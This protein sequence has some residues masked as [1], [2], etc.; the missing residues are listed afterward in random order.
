MKRGSLSTW[1]MLAAFAFPLLATAPIQVNSN[2]ATEPETATPP[3]LAPANS[4]TPL[5]PTNLFAGDNLAPPEI[6]DAAF[7]PI[8]PVKPL[9]PTIRPTSPVAEVIKLANS[10]LDQSVLL[11][12]VTNS[13]STFNLDADKIIYLNDIG[14]PGDV[15]SAMIQRDQQ[16]RAQSDAAAAALVSTPLPAPGPPPADSTPAPYAVEAPPTAPEDNMDPA[17]Y[18]TLAPYG[19]WVDVNGYGPCWQPSVVVINSGWQPYFDCGHWAYS[20]CGWYWCSDYSWGWAPFHYGRWFRHHNLGWC[21]RP[22]RVWGPSWVCWSYSGDYCGWAPLPPAAGFSTGVG[23]T[24]AGH[25]APSGCHFGLGANH[26][27]YVAWNHFSDRHLRPYSLGPNQTEHIF[28]QSAVT[29]GIAVQNNRIVNIGISPERVAAATHMPVNQIALHNVGGR[30]NTIP[31][32]TLSGVSS[33]GAS[34]FNNG[35]FVGSAPQSANA[36]AGGVFATRTPSSSAWTTPSPNGLA[37]NNGAELPNH[38]DANSSLVVHGSQQ[39][40]PPEAN[41]RAPAN[42]LVVIGRNNQ[43]SYPGQ[44]NPW[45]TGMP[46]PQTPRQGPIQSSE[47]PIERT[48]NEVPRYNYTPVGSPFSYRAAQAPAMPSAPRAAVSDTTRY[49]QPAATLAPARPADTRSAPAAQ[50]APTAGAG[51]GH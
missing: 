44:Q 24:Y 14:V 37:R 18:D 25:P 33:T 26:F 16:I 40:W 8:S 20:N 12:F 7:T 3:D 9:P 27:H 49:S 42:S 21:W 10:G 28:G 1:R 15:V 36:T 23:L 6:S 29:T 43:G 45:A 13:T 35:R 5:A 38:P 17:F 41:N 39:I 48:V 22:E 46:M 31:Q 34:S 2:A 51:R 32:R 19:T 47:I 4:A 50:T 11:A 30:P